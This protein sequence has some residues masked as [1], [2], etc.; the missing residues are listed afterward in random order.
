MTFIF[1]FE[2]SSSFINGL[3]IRCEVLEF[4]C[5]FATESTMQNDRRDSAFPSLPFVRQI[6]AG[7]YL[8]DAKSP[9]RGYATGND[10]AGVVVPRR[11]AAN[12]NT[13]DL[14]TKVQG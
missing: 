1:I 4:M 8:C 12:A 6:Y 13:A 9:L 3:R 2:A 7:G 10:I 5:T 11:C 14:Q